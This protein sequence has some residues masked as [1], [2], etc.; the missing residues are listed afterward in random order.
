ME[1]LELLIIFFY[2]SISPTKKSDFQNHILA[3]IQNYIINRFKTVWKES[4]EYNAPK[5]LKFKD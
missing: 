5:I 2:F 3:S 1:K 4:Q